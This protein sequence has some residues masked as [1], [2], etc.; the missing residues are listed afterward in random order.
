MRLQIINMPTLKQIQDEAEGEYRQIFAGYVP[1]W[2][3]CKC[4][5]RR[6]LKS[7]NVL[8]FLRTQISLAYNAGMEAEAVGCVEHCK[9]AENDVLE[10]VEKWAEVEMKICLEAK[11]SEDIPTNSHRAETLL[12][13][14]SFINKLK[15]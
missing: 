13:L 7:E 8:L 10:Q 11:Y 12:D 15:K 2:E 4:G 5:E 3:T 9:N 6:W 14:L 1:N